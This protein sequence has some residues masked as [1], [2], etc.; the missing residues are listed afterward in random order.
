MVLMPAGVAQ[1]YVAWLDG[2]RGFGMLGLIVAWTLYDRMFEPIY[3]FALRA[4]YAGVH[5]S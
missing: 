4:L 5:G 1:R 2:A 3:I